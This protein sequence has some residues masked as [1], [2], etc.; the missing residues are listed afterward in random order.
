MNDPGH[1]AFRKLAD[2][3]LLLQPG[4]CYGKKKV[5]HLVFSRLSPG[6]QR[7]DQNHFFLLPFSHRLSGTD[8]FLFL[9]EIPFH[10]TDGLKKITRLIQAAGGQHPFPIRLIE[11]NIL[12]KREIFFLLLQIRFNIQKISG[13]LLRIVRI[14]PFI[15]SAFRIIKIDHAHLLMPVFLFPL[16][17][18][19]EH[20]LYLLYLLSAFHDK[21]AAEHNDHWYQQNKIIGNHK[22]NIV[23][24]ACFLHTYSSR[25]PQSCLRYGIHQQLGRNLPVSSADPCITI[26]L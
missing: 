1:A 14:I 16:A 13:R 8:G 2:S 24:F 17:I 11:I 9:R 7:T 15:I 5:L 26:V 18:A 4:P 23:E 22:M 12:H 25:I 19:S 3:K 21:D 20:R 10:H 6:T